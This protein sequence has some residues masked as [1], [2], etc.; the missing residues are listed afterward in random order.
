[1]TTSRPS[2]RHFAL[3]RHPVFVLDGAGADRPGLA[4]GPRDAQ[5][6]RHLRGRGPGGQ[7]VHPLKHGQTYYE[8]RA[9]ALD[10]VIEKFKQPSTFEEFISHVYSPSQLGTIIQ[11][12]LRSAGTSTA[13][14]ANT[15]PGPH[16]LFG[17]PDISARTRTW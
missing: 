4:E 16:L 14:V 8:E 17:L 1:M 2:P 15:R 13:S 3:A 7:A 12:N 11:G 10:S 6:Q 5:D 9:K